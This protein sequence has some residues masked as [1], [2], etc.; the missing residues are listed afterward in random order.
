MHKRNFSLT[1]GTCFNDDNY[2]I[3]AF[4][5]KLD[6]DDI[7]VLL[8]EAEDLDKVIAT[9]RWMVKRDTAKVLDG[10]SQNNQDSLVEIV[11]PKEDLGSS[12]G[13][14]CGDKKLDW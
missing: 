6:G 13:T 7:S 9:S 1:S 2:S 14:A 11:G 4:D 12:C 8:P 3:I 5:V 10:A